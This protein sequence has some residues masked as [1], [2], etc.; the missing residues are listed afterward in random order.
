VKH[1][2]LLI[3]YMFTSTKY[4]CTWSRIENN[5]YVW[6]VSRCHLNNEPHL[7]D[8]GDFFLYYTIKRH[9]EIYWSVCPSHLE[10]IQTYKLFSILDQVQIYFVLVNIYHINKILCWQVFTVHFYT[11]LLTIWFDLVFCNFEYNR[12]VLKYHYNV[13]FPSKYKTDITCAYFFYYQRWWRC[14]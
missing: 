6:M 13:F 7:W 14:H 1:K 8:N 12:Q 9:V 2:I 3:W 11:D 5:L 4:I 10:T